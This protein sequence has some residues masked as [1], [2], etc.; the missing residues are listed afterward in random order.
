MMPTAVVAA[1]VLLEGM[2]MAGPRA[3]NANRASTGMY[4]SMPSRKHQRNFLLAH[5][6]HSLLSH[7]C[8]PRSPFLCTSVSAHRRAGLIAILAL[9]EDTIRPLEQRL[10]A[11]PQNQG[12]MRTMVPP[13]QPVRALS[14]CQPRACLG[15]SFLLKKVCLLLLVLC[16]LWLLIISMLRRQLQ[17]WIAR[18]VHG[19]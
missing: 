8:H 4:E 18:M 12:V 16:W 5:A 17:R 7:V 10:I 1:P 6:M 19:L 15:A 11:G 13:Y 9:E 14:R 3:Q 2:E